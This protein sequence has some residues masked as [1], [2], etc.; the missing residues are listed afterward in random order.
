M[1]VRL[2]PLLTSCSGSLATHRRTYGHSRG[3]SVQSGQAQS[4]TS[5][6]KK[7]RAAPGSARSL[8]AS[9]PSLIGQDI[10]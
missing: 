9:R 6:R 8:I 2:L 5:R 1:F 3:P 7:P 10:T 4:G